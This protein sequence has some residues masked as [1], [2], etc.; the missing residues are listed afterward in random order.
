[1]ASGGMNLVQSAANELGNIGSVNIG[2]Q[3]SWAELGASGKFA[4]FAM[5]TFAL[6]NALPDIMLRIRR[7][8]DLGQT[9]WLV[10]VF[11]LV[12]A[13]PGIGIIADLVNLVWFTMR[14]TAGANQYGPD[15]LQSGNDIFG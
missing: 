9:G 3:T 7:F 4:I 13:I 6:I 2:L 11:M 8:H 14:G 12:G 15:P 5:V 10:L 1:M